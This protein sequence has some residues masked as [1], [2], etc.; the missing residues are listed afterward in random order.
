MV[1]L[2]G[3]LDQYLNLND[4]FNRQEPWYEKVI[5][6]FIAVVRYDVKSHRLRHQ[7]ALDFLLDKCGILSY[8]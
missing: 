3:S 8:T 4:S 7:Q 1:F 2:F 6:F 5:H